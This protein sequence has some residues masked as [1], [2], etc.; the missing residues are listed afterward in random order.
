MLGAAAEVNREAE[1]RGSLKPGHSN[2]DFT[3]IIFVFDLMQQVFDEGLCSA[4]LNG[5]AGKTH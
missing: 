4:A 2:L 1:P 5:G 3:G